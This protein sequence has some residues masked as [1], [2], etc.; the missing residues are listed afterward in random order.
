MLSWSASSVARHAAWVGG[1]QASR[2]SLDETKVVLC[3][4]T[5]D[6]FRFGTDVQQLACVLADRLEH[7]EA[8]A[9][10]TDEA[11]VD[12]RA[13]VVEL[14]AA[15]LFDCVERAAPDED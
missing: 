7:A 9:L 13:E 6:A 1:R 10:D 12:E 3:V 4:C 8:F 2:S 5:P 15:H 11:L 14:A